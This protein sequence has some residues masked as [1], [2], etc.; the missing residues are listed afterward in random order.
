MVCV[1]RAFDGTDWRNGW[2]HAVV[3]DACAWNRS[4]EHRRRCR[5]S[6]RNPTW[7]LMRGMHCILAHL[8]SRQRLCLDAHPITFPSVEAPRR[9]TSLVVVRLGL[10]LIGTT[11][12]SVGRWNPIPTGL[13]DRGKEP[14][15]RRHEDD[16]RA[17]DQGVGGGARWRR[18]N[19]WRSVARSSRPDSRSG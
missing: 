12:G 4:E 7:H 18:T 10:G 15:H 16:R 8:H 1:S 5:G 3:W 6:T 17:H 13:H 11:F 19:G 9:R 2:H 14:S